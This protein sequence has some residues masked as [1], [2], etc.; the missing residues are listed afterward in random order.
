[1]SLLPE[2]NNVGS[3]GP[4]GEVMASKPGVGGEGGRPPK[5]G[6]PAPG[7]AGSRRSGLFR[8][9]GQAG[10]GTSKEM[11][12]ALQGMRGSSRVGTPGPDLE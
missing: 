4:S 10:C 12:E 2:M 6:T 7:S 9:V 8:E 5:E 3:T 1:M 11:V